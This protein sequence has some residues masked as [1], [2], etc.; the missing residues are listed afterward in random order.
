MRWNLDD[1][2]CGIPVEIRFD[3]LR[4]N[5]FKS[6]SVFMSHSSECNKMK[7]V[8]RPPLAVIVV[9]G[10]C[11][12]RVRLFLVVSVLIGNIV[13][14]VNSNSAVQGTDVFF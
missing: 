14:Y 5:A 7:C 6:Y 13:G 10:L 12:R 1:M 8:I 9:C 2:V 4:K 3:D 11:L